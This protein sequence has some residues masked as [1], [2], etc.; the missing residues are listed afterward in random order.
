MHFCN[1]AVLDIDSITALRLRPFGFRLAS[2]ETATSCSEKFIIILH[3]NNNNNR[4]P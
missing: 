3:N 2:R 1:V 4:S